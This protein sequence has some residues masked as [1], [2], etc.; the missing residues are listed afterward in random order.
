M[1][2][3]SFIVGVGVAVVAPQFAIPGFVALEAYRLS[4]PMKPQSFVVVQPPWLQEVESGF[5][6][7]VGY[8]IGNAAMVYLFG[9]Q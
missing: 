5:E 1:T 6:Y 3:F 8:Y 7:A 2:T 4:A 9:A